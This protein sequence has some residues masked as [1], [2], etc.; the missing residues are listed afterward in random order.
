[1][2]QQHMQQDICASEA[3]L[4]SQHNLSR[5]MAEIYSRRPVAAQGNLFPF[6]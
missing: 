1:M 5:E 2:L 4:I 6:E 3:F